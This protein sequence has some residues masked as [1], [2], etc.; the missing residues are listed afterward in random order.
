[1]KL[2]LL[3]C[4]KCNQ[5]LS[6][7]QDDQII[8]CPNCRAAVAVSEGGLALLAAQYAAPTVAQPASWLPFWVYRG[9]VTI[10]QRRTQGGRSAEKDAQA[11]WAQPRRVYIPAWACELAEA[12]DLVAALLE[13]QPFLEAIIPPEGAAFEPAAVTPADA[14]KLLELVI[15]SL[16]ARRDDYLESFDFDLNLESEALWLLPAERRDDAWQLLLKR[17]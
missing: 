11:F 16:E 1:M 12:R 5:A 2:L 7:G 6:P 9:R 15:V 8:Q 17:F 10:K 13:K 4:P 3:R 14:R